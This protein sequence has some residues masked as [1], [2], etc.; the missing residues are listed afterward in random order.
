MPHAIRLTLLTLMFVAACGARRP[1]IV[2]MPPGVR[3]E[4]DRCSD[5]I[6]RWCVDHS[7]GLVSHERECMEQES[8]RF[9]AL[10]EDSARAS[11]M[12]SHGCTR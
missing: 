10:Q 8:A 7:H 1:E 3:A 4:W 6:E 2:S 9:A 12:A 5:H 11:Y